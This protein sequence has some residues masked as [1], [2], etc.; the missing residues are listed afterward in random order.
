[1]RP[2]TKRRSVFF[3]NYTSIIDC[4]RILTMENLTIIEPSN[5]RISPRAVLHFR[6][7]AN[8]WP[9]SSLTSSLWAVI[10]E[11]MM[12]FIRKIRRNYFSEVSC[13]PVAAPGISSWCSFAS[14]HPPGDCSNG[15]GTS[16]QCTRSSVLSDSTTAVPKGL[17]KSRH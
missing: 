2:F 6:M 11:I 7:S 13:R 4:K 5:S 1:M 9:V 14:A 12:L 8:G 3:F 10:N 15:E 17:F 16:G